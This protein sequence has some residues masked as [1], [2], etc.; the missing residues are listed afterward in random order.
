MRGAVVWFTGLPAS[1]K[2]TLA[3][4]VTDQLRERSLPCCLLD[5]DEFRAKVLPDLGYDPDDRGAFY[6]ALAGTAAL[7]ARQDLI[8]CVAATAPLREYRVHARRIAPRFF[9]VYVGTA[10]EVCKQRDPKGLYRK[11]AAGE[12]SGLPGVDAAYERPLQPEYAASGDAA[13]A[14]EIVRRLVAARA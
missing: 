14:S 8:V 2:T 4:G 10:L 12:V 1:G 6:R 11:A 3:R 7:L 9:E 5:S 13:D